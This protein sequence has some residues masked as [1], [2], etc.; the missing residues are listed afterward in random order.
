M[1][2][3]SELNK[4]F[5]INTCA[6]GLLLVSFLV[7]VFCP[8]LW[9]TTFSLE[10]GFS[11]KVYPLRLYCWAC[12][13]VIHRCSQWNIFISCSCDKSE[14]VLKYIGFH[15]CLLFLIMYFPLNF[16]SDQGSACFEIQISISYGVPLLIFH[17]R[18]MFK[19][20]K[21]NKR[22]ICRVLSLLTL[23]DS[24]WNL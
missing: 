8:A 22:K 9:S 21:K 12:V 4:F 3:P 6:K 23:Q 1:K 17:F 11:L 10:A 19:K 15:C 20:R 16:Y 18:Y 2:S 14:V 7:G 13:L 24:R 5:F